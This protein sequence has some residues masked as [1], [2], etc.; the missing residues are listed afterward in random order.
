MLIFTLDGLKHIPSNLFKSLDIV[1]LDAL[2][3][4]NE[5]KTDKNSAS[6]LLKRLTGKDFKT[7]KV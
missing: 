2:E 5:F 1:L 4:I 7:D 6:I 3:L